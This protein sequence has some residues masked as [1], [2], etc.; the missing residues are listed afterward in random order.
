MTEAKKGDR[1]VV[2][3]VVRTGDG[4]V[5]GDTK[6]EG[7]QTL[8]LGAEAIFTEVDDCLTGMKAGEEK[9]VTVPA[10]RA[11]GSRREEL[12]VQIPPGAAS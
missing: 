8:T 12:V 5:V 11:F 10:D 6:R 7:S 3:Y 4:R 2:D 9:S 1:V